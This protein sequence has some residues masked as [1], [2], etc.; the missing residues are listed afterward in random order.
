MN[1][2]IRKIKNNK[3]VISIIGLGYVGLP[4][5][6]AFSKK[7]FKV[8]GI[9]KDKFKIKCLNSHRSYIERITNLQLKQISNNFIPTT[10]Y[11]KIIESDIII[12]CLPT[13]LKKNKSPDMSYIRDAIDNSKIYFKNGHILSLESTTYPG[14]TNDFF[15]KTLKKE[16]FIVGS[17]IHLIYSPEREDPG[18]KYFHIKNTTKIVAGYSKQCMLIGKELYKKISKN[19]HTTSS[20]NIA[21]TTKLFE[22]VYRSVN[23]SLVN[24]LKILCDKMD[25]DVFEV[26]KAA[27]TK[28]FGFNAF[29]PGPGLGGHCIPV[30][31]FLLSWKVKKFGLNADFIEL[32]GRVNEKMPFFVFKKIKE[33]LKNL[34]TSSQKKILIIGAAYKKNIRDTRET[35][36]LKLA[37]LLISKNIN[38]DFHDPFVSKIYIT[39]K[40]IL[41]KGIVFQYSK[42]KNY[43]VVTILTDHD[44]YDYKKIFINSKKIIDTRGR[45]DLLN[46]K[47]VRA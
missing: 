21:E 36:F 38:F 10:S 37:E 19:I 33:I 47:V 40:K 11:R 41:K 5:A 30:D 8:F 12:Y 46:K 39:N 29:Y 35:P 28:P 45:F 31:P 44:I 3:S 16:K 18:N 25:I 2:Q 9:D 27:K 22:N 32:S 1:D 13:P 7:G 15:V 26:I 17:D 42:L 23:I 4:L 6:H 24:E 20:I 14:T 43:D 34:K